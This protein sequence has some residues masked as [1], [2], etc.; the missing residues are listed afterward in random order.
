MNANINKKNILITNNPKFKEVNSHNIEIIYFPDL[1]FMGI[2][3][4]ARDYIHLYYKLL[5]H[6]I[7]SSIK[8]Y[9]NSV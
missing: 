2:L 1:D 8:P 7:V 5:T 4:K 6:P 3:Y 9:E